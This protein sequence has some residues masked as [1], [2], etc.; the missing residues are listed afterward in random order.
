MPPS[1]GRVAGALAAIYVIWGS[2][3]LAIRVMVETIPPLLGAGVRF[4]V[5]G[6]LMYAW[7]RWRRS[8]VRVSRAELLACGLVGV[9]LMFGGNGLVTVAEQD[10]P[11]GL[12][13]LLI[14]SEPL[15]IIVLRALWRE[16]PGRVSALGV[17]AGFAGV[18]LLLAPGE[19]PEGASLAACLL[20]V[21]AAVCWASGSFAGSRLPQPSDPLHATALQMLLGG[22]VMSAAAVAVGEPW[23]LELGAVS[24]DSWIAFAYLV[25]IGSIVAFTAYAWLLRNVPISTVSTYAYVN[26]VIAV[27][28][29]WAILSEPVSPI[30]IAATAIIVA[31]VALTM[32]EEGTGREVEPAA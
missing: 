9:L 17:I 13:A 4:L 24:G 30:T 27:F 32:R 26:P 16:R 10:V 8:P 2:T 22:A 3:Y 31:S 5:A 1:P 29:G 12:A 18:A 28:L 7:V 11:S 23:D 6:A 14:A 21:F 20:V 19:R 25:A 15:W